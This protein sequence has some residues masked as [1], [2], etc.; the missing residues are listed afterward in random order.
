MLLTSTPIQ[1]PAE[2]WLE[3]EWGRPWADMSFCSCLCH[4]TSVL[5]FSSLS[6]HHGGAELS[7]LPADMSLKNEDPGS[8]P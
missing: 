5:C 1:H 3:E 6:L 7:L 2:V 8:Q 4:L